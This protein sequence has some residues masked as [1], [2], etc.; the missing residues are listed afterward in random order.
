[1]IVLVKSDPPARTLK[2]THLITC[3]ESVMDPAAHRGAT[4]NQVPAPCMEGARRHHRVGRLKASCYD[5]PHP[6]NPENF[7][8]L[9]WCRFVFFKYRNCWEFH[10]VFLWNTSG[11]FCG[12]RWFPKANNSNDTWLWRFVLFW[13]EAEQGSLPLL[14]GSVQDFASFSSER[15]SS[16]ESLQSWENTEQLSYR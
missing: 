2:D 14:F 11:C 5:G 10:S 6:Q 9:P 1:M 12:S 15:A 4:G 8:M 3:P 16:W 13:K 7:L